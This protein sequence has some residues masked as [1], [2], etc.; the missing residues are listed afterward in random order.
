[1]FDEITNNSFFL[2]IVSSP[3]RGFLLEIKN[4]YWLQMMNKWKY[5]KKKL[6]NDL[7]K[8]EK[9]KVWNYCSY[10]KCQK[11]K[12]RAKWQLLNLSSRPGLSNIWSTRWFWNK[13]IAIIIFIL[14]KIA[15]QGVFSESKNFCSVH[16]RM[17]MVKS[18]QN[19]GNGKVGNY[20]KKQFHTDYLWR[21]KWKS[22]MKQILKMD[23]SVVQT[24]RNL[25]MF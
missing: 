9:I 20:E 23:N 17:N 12:K 5:Y 8:T 13:K 24:G 6:I 21:V 22:K 14:I 3:L 4:V 16:L 1:M 15:N 7:F 19:F 11:L 25:P 10:W 18:A 2:L